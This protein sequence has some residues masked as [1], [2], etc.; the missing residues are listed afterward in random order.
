V[1]EAIEQVQLEELLHE[2]PVQAGDVVFVPAGTVHAI[3]GGILLYELQEYSDVTYRMY[4]YGRLDA[5]GNP[6]ELHI[7]RSLDVSH[8]VPSPSIKQRPVVL[9][10]GADYRDRC[11][12]ACNYF[13][14]REIILKTR[15]SGQ[16]TT[17]CIILTSLGAKLSV[18]TNNSVVISLKRGQTV[19]LPASLG[20]FQLEGEGAF[21]Y[22]YVPVEDDDAWQA[23]QQQN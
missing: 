15:F 20:T 3:G 12:V 17:S 18:H 16:T 19:V 21:L 2:E 5:L 14:T 9:H 11:L 1:L 8:Y 4:D 10:E 7:A 23:W 13:L 6:R 22:S